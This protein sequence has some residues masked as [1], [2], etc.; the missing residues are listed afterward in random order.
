[1]ADYRETLDFLRKNLDEITRN[2]PDKYVFVI[3]HY[4]TQS[5]QT[6]THSSYE[7]PILIPNYIIHLG[8]TVHN[9][10]WDTASAQLP[11][12]L[13]LLAVAVSPTPRKIHE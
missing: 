12:I 11:Q 9:P 7:F 8:G 2:E 3:C 4:H 13:V 10:T 5:V 6:T 1:M